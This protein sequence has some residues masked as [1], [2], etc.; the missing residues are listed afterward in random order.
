MDQI[1]PPGPPI[2]FH[3]RLVALLGPFLF[4]IDA[5][6]LAYAITTVLT[7]G[8][9]GKLLFVNEFTVLLTS[10]GNVVGRYGVNL[11]EQWRARKIRHERERVRL[12]AV[13]A[14]EEDVEEDEEE[15]SWE[16]KS[17]VVFYIDLVT[18]MSLFYTSSRP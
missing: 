7:T 1:P 8:I 12:A 14:G 9:N 5:S 16:G 6:L 17:M 3:V 18:G 15:E 13:A 10:W 2:L 4:L 11:W